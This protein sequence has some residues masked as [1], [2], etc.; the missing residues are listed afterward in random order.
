MFSADIAERKTFA[1]ALR[2]ACMRVGILYIENY[3]I[4]NGLV[5]EA[6]RMG[7]E[8]LLSCHLRGRWRFILIIPC[9]SGDIRRCMGVGSRMP[10]ENEAT[11]YLT[12]NAQCS[13]GIPS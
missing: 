11:S 8:V 6:F 13:T 5:D 9:I 3:G 10:R 4:L 12:P 1:A 2:D 7:Q